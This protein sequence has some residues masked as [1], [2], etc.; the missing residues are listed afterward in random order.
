MKAMQLLAVTE[1]V[2]DTKERL[3]RYRL[4]KGNS[5]PRF[6]G[7]KNPFAPPPVRPAEPTG[8]AASSPAM[9]PMPEEEN[10]PAA[11]SES[12]GQRAESAGVKIRPRG[13]L[14]EPW[15]RLA[16]AIRKWFASRKSPSG[17]R[18]PAIRLG[19]QPVRKRPTD[20]PVQGEFSLDN[21]RVVRNDLRDS[22]L[23][24]VP[25]RSMTARKRAPTAVAG[26]DEM[27][28]AKTWDRWTTRW[29][30]AAHDQAR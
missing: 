24:V 25:L 22:D 15:R 11:S 26:S 20:F 6:G 30:R 23:E 12:D 10:A 13:N 9:A 19:Q 18:R 8:S 16:S 28:D 27:A 3:G 17:S 1:S 21:V 29:L 7:T 5:L 14:A 4:P 2:V